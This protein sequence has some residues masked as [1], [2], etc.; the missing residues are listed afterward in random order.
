[1]NEKKAVISIDVEDW[2]HLDYFKNPQKKNYSMIDGLNKIRSVLSETNIPSSYFMLSD[3]L[4]IESQDI[5]EV[6]NTEDDIGVHGTDH[7]RPLL[8]SNIQFRDDIRSAI[9]LIEE[10]SGKEITG[11]RAP[12]FSLDRD[13]LNIVMDTKIKYDSSFIKFND[14]PLYGKID[15]KGFKKIGDGISHMDNFIEFEVSTVNF[16]SKNLP[17]SGGGYLRTIPWPIF[18]NLL[19]KYIK[20]NNF[21][22]IFL[23]P[24]EFSEKSAN[25]NDINDLSSINK[26]RFLHNQSSGEARL[27]RLIEFLKSEGY[28]FT[29]FKSLHEEYHNEMMHKVKDV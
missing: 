9:D 1:M 12:C 11:Y 14:H 8:Q 21:Y 16:L 27:R 2:Y 6:I 13:K 24:F 26:F 7:T 19:K 28:S 18:K 25:P 5:Q 17:I 23:H 20:K 29:T 15:L 22:N 10:A 4:D 3:V